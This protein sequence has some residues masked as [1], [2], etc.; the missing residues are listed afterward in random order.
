[1][2]VTWKLM[3]SVACLAG[4]QMSTSAP[5]SA[6]ATD[7]AARSARWT[8]L[9]Q[10]IFKDRRVL[11]GT[12]VLDLQAP[13][14]ALDAALVPLTV[15]MTGSPAVKRLYIVIDNNPSP[16]AGRFTFGP[17]ADPRTLKVRMRVN[18]YTDVRAVAET[19]DGKLYAV[20]KFVKAAG[21]CSA[22]AGG[23]DAEALEDLGRMKVRLLDDFSPGKPIQAQL[24][25]RHPN[26]NGMQ[27]NQLTR[28]YTPAHFIRAIDVTY[29][30]ENVLRVESDIT[31][32][33]D[34]VITFGFVPR[35]KGALS[36]LV[37]D[38]KDLRFERAFDV[39][40]AVEVATETRHGGA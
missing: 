18:E 7:D 13:A 35:K 19:A 2:G 24:M 25:V 6:A 16:L 12:G 17:A 30:G 3:L 37:E 11:D 1:M 27:M 15:T 32:S 9:Q 34:P 4:A 28:Y 26:F 21:G 23:D 8:Q 29:A 31:L 14:R 10:A 40:A 38:S 39:P 22:P 20:S 36:V 33:T 5:A